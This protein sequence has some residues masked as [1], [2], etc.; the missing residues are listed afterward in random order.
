VSVS[1]C[2]FAVPE[3]QGDPEEISREKCKI[4]AK[5]VRSFSHF[6]PSVDIHSITLTLYGLF[7]QV[8]GPVIVEDTSLCFNALGGLPGPYMFVVSN[9]SMFFYFLLVTASQR[10]NFEF[11]LSK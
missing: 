1:D 3:L 7:P 5:A 4:A 10:P 6:L 11:S 9:F 2:N 8:G